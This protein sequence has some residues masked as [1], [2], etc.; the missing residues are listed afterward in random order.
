M[1]V[2]V[3]YNKREI[4]PSDVINTF[5]PQTRET[6]NPRTVELVASALEKGGHNVRVIEGNINVADSLR[7]FMPRELAGERP[8]MVFNMAYGIQGQSRYTHLPATL[9]MLGVPY[10]G[11]GPQ[12]HA[13]ALDKIL[14]KI[15]FQQHAVPTP[16]FWFFTNPEDDLDS[17]TFPVIVK[18]KMEAVSMGLKIVDNKDDLREAVREIV[19][20]YQQQALVEAFVA[21]REFAVGLLGNGGELEVLPI[22]EFDF[23]GDP[24]AIQSYSDK[25]SKPAEKV[26]PAHLS[27]EKAEEL[28]QLARA[29]FNALGLCDFSRIDVRMDADGKPYVLEINSMASLGRTGSYVYASQAAGYSYDAL[30]N[31]MLD[32]AA[33]R[34]FGPGEPTVAPAATTKPDDSQPLRVQVRSHVR[35]HLTTM[36][37][38]LRY[39]VGM[40]T[41]VY[42]TEGVN[43][44]GT[45]LSR[46]LAQLRFKKQVYPQT[47]VGNVLYF[48]NH[49]GNRNDIVLLSHLDTLYSYR[50]FVSFREERGRFHGS[51]VA[52]SKGGLAVMLAALRALRFTRRLHRIRCGVLLTTDDALGGRFSRTIIDEI[53][54]QSSYVVSLKNGGLDGG[55]VTSCSGWSDYQVELSNSK[56]IAN[57]QPPDVIRLLCQRLMAWDRLSSEA[58][59]IYV[60]A[61]QLEGRTLYGMAPD[62]ATTALSVRFREPDQG[63][64]LEGQIRD[65]ARRNAPP[66]CQI[67]VLKRIS[68]PPVVHNE[69]DLQFFEHVQRIARRLEVKVVPIHRETSSDICHVPSRIPALEGF[70]PLGG[71]NQTPNEYILRDSLIDRAA[72]LAM[73]TRLAAEGFD[74]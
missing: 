61:T 19:E 49:D 46:Q 25:M 42:N 3:I 5:G 29:S 74:L 13:V 71:A 1:K 52:E 2:A 65:S 69:K 41:Y 23:A 7:A 38:D 68:R 70:G 27:D 43:E 33:V 51:G 17:V 20:K 26:C 55:I 6:Y 30:V 67:R 32:V 50:D 11:S 56:G 31:R 45:W 54:R 35:S 60:K 8:G 66:H 10:V 28:R 48:T 39:M 12:A 37:D 21:G 36:E 15:V 58:Q 44:F 53:S 63:A 14:A 22:V 64:R 40:D 9:E 4:H 59:G 47:E 24:N 34:Y 18:P 57:G 62:F 72:L 73:T 16:R